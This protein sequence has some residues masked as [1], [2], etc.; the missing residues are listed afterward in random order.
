M[1]KKVY[2]FTAVIL[3]FT[4]LFKNSD[5]KALIEELEQYLSGNE[6]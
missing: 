1:K 6:L 2:N 4:M 5:R 3:S